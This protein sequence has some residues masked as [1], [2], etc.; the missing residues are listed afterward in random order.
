[1]WG[2]DAKIIKI[3][4]IPTGGFLGQ[5]EANDPQGRRQDLKPI[6]KCTTC[7][8]V[9]VTHR[10]RDMGPPTDHMG[11]QN[12]GPKKGPFWLLKMSQN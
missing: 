3:G 4:V 5:A 10:L 6:S 7:N 1:M 9:Q 11:G 2:H 8:W 12:W